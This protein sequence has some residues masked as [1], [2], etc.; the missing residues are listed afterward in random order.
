M[1]AATC[2][3]LDLAAAPVQQDRVKAWEYFR[4]G[5]DVSRLSNGD[6]C[7]TGVETVRYVMTHP[8]L[9]SN[10][11]L[12]ELEHCPVDLIPEGVDPPHHRRFRSR[13]NPPFAPQAL[14]GMM[15]EFRR[16]A[17]EL[18]GRF[19]Q[20]GNCEIM[21]ELA[22]PFPATIFLT[23][24][25][26]PASDTDLLIGMVRGINGGEPLT[27]GM[28]Q[29]EYARECSEALT[30][31]LREAIAQRRERPVDDLLSSIIAPMG[32]DQWTDDELLGFG[33]QFTLA[34]LDTVAS[35]TGFVFRYLAQHPETRR[36]IIQDPS[37]IPPLI[38]EL[39]RI[40]NV[41]P[42]NHRRT[43]VDVELGG[44]IIPS[45]STV[46]VSLATANMDPEHFSNPEQ[47]DPNREAGH[48]AFGTGIHRCIGSHLARREL[49][50]LVEEFHKQIPDYELASTPEAEIEWPAFILAWDAVP[51]VFS[52]PAQ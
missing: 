7:V 34:G 4:S 35:T 5:G 52:P 29:K 10:S 16:Q 26:L 25:G 3:V 27:S 13:L 23:M 22:R 20:R 39:L 21:E 2:P 45:G 49:R 37:L 6:W 18:I 28:S 48:F 46:W 42:F 9:F 12:N 8:E 44:Q 30:A 15:D 36:D 51:L 41:V 43:V 32:D 50:V 38:E 1:E 11:I 19:V 33:Y 24:M 14:D 31:Y 40:E 47:I 17:Q